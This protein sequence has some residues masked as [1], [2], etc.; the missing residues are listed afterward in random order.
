M[1][2]TLDVIKLL[3]AFLFFTLNHTILR[4]LNFENFGIFEVFM[5]FVSCAVF[6]YA[7]IKNLKYQ[8]ENSFCF[9]NVIFHCN[10]LEFSLVDA[11]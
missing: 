8:S 3:I 6:C 5:N 11:N 10:F 7:N 9:E 4:I 1:L 2:M